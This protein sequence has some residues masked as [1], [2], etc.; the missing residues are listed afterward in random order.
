MSLSVTRQN[1]IFSV[2]NTAFT[3]AEAEEMVMEL[4]VTAGE[5][6]STSRSSAPMAAPFH[7]K[8]SLGQN[9]VTTAALSG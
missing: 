6:A 9:T 4:K 7:P 5:Q 3:A 2:S 1:I 8:T